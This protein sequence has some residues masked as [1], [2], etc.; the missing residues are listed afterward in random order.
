MVVV[1]EANSSGSVSWTTMQVVPRTQLVVGYA[2]LETYR[3]EDLSFKD[4]SRPETVGSPLPV[5]VVMVS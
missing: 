5:L 4:V 1:Y 3:T 2:K